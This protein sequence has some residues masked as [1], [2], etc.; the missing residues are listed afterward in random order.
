MEPMSDR[1]EYAR[2]TAAT[3][4]A[5]QRLGRD[6]HIARYLLDGEEV[7]DDWAEHEHRQSDALFARERLG[8]WLVRERGA[9]ESIG[10]AGFRV[11]DEIGGAIVLYELE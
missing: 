6:P 7:V 2:L 3:T 5:L 11:F 8:L 9:T 10:F 4:S 1:L